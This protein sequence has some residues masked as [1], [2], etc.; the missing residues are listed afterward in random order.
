MKLVTLVLMLMLVGPVETAL[1]QKSAEGLGAPLA[2]QATAPQE[3]ATTQTA[4]LTLDEAVSRALENNLDIAVQRLNPQIAD[5]DVASA[6]A[7]FLPTFDSTIGTTSRVQPS[8]TQLDG[9]QRVVVDTATYNAGL[10]KALEW[11]GAAI[12]ASWSHNRNAT[13]SIFSSFN[14][15]YRSNF[16]FIYTQPLLRGFKIDS[17]RQ[18]LQV[19]RLSRELS[20]I[21]LRRMV[22]NTEAAVRSAY[23]D[24]VI[25]SEAIAVQQQFVELAED[26]ITDNQARVE[27]GTLAPIDIIQSQ[28]EAAQRR[29]V[30]TEALQVRRTAEL[31]LKRL[32]VSGTDDVLWE[33]EVVPV[34]RPRFDASPV[35]IEA[36]IRAALAQRTDIARSRRQLDINDINLRAARDTTL[37]ALDL[38]A[39]YTLQGLGG[40]QFVRSGLGGEVGSILSGG[41]VDSLNQLIG[42]DYPAWNVSMTLS[43]PLGQSAAETSYARAQIQAKQTQAQIEQMELQI[44][45]EVT[46]AGLQIQSSLRR[47][48]AATAAR[49]LARQR[50][51]AEQS[52][53]EVGASTNFFVVQA[54][55]DLAD[56]QRAELQAILD[57][58]KSRIEF[59]RSQQTSLAQGSIIIVSGGGN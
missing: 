58:Q 20:D 35:D 21:D 54:Q 27:L 49:E 25:A 5:L 59:D 50:L 29:Q 41:Y 19:T 57:H 52:K 36:A 4:R 39:S 15:S 32:L 1:A 16:D 8:T 38:R 45:T 37:P 22:T 3:S 40:T 23:W 44:A 14:P 34:D 10:T 26:L 13:T 7:A 55:R 47:I 17:N 48:E 33:A 31:I 51:D 2:E 30:L 11:G 56:A 53:F 12:D 9:G 6:H 24:L 28:A 43:Y 46:N 42:N 18:R